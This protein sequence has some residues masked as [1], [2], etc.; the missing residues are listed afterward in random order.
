MKC[1]FTKD[2]GKQCG[3]YHLRNDEYCYWHS[4]AVPEADKLQ[5][6]QYGGKARVIKVNGS[7]KHTKLETISEVTKLNAKLINDVL[8]DILDLRCGVGLSSMLNLQLKLIEIGE[9]EK[10][11][12][13][14]EDWKEDNE[15]KIKN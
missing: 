1:K 13:K 5:A 6:R 11:L 10:R 15:F 2:N 9:F 7:Y 14:I 12:V 3:N 4:D 8:Q